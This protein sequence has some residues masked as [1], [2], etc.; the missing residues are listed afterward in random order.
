MT[1]RS[2][3]CLWIFVFSLIRNKFLNV[4]C[5]IC[6]LSIYSTKYPACW[7]LTGIIL[8]RPEFVTILIKITILEKYSYKA[9]SHYYRSRIISSVRKQNYVMVISHLIKEN[10]LIDIMLPPHSVAPYCCGITYSYSPLWLCRS[11]LVSAWCW[12]QLQT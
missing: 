1:V 7:G 5:Y 4:V 2:G 11:L 9:L 6:F 3:V 8:A 12:V 10:K